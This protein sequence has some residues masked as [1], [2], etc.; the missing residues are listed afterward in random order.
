MSPTKRHKLILLPCRRKSCGPGSVGQGY[1]VLSCRVCALL[2]SVP[3]PYPLP[4]PRKYGCHMIDDF[5]MCTS[6]SERSSNLDLSCFKQDFS[7]KALDGYALSCYGSA[8]V[9]TLAGHTSIFSL[10]LARVQ[11]MTS[12]ELLVPN[13]DNNTIVNPSN[14]N[15]LR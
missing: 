5:Q 3:Q 1:L 13:F 8:E 2:L 12:V 10:C 11:Q 7:V 6:S 4:W 15:N 9:E 14:L